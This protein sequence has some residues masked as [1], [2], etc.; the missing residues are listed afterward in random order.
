MLIRIRLYAGYYSFPTAALPTNP[1]NHSLI[2]DLLWDFSL[3][4]IHCLISFRMH[5]LIKLDFPPC[6]IHLIQSAPDKVNSAAR[7]KCLSLSMARSSGM[8]TMI[9]Y[10]LWLARVHELELRPS[11]GLT[12]YFPLLKDPSSSG[13]YAVGE[14]NMVSQSLNLREHVH[15]SRAETVERDILAVLGNR[16]PTTLNRN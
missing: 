14:M 15:A 2:L 9:T 3:A 4:C 13:L 10:R 12:N 8:H 11:T 16:N 7:T 6:F 1:Q 5:R